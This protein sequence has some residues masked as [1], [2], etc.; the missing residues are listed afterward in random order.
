MITDEDDDD[1]GVQASAGE[2]LHRVEPAYLAGVAVISAGSE[3][4]GGWHSN[5]AV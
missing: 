3:V 1:E 4:V 5:S 2:F